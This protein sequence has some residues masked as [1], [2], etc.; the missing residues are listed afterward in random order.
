MRNAARALAGIIALLYL[1]FGARYMFAPA[2]I[3][4]TAGFEVV[5]ELGF[6]TLRAIVGGSFLAFGILLVMHTVVNQ[7]TGALRFSILFL[8]LSI[9]GRIISMVT[10]G[11]VDG[12]VRNLVPVSL[13]FIVCIVSL[14]LFQKSEPAA[15]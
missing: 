7:E 1:V 3:I 5:N 11:V 10:D 2:G 14:V 8:L 9:V 6:A 12:T 4:E 13:M 15:G